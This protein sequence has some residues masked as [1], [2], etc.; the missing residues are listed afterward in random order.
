M[1]EA[2]HSACFRSPIAIAVCLQLRFYSLCRLQMALKPVC[3]IIFM[4]CSTRVTQALEPSP[5]SKKLAKPL[6]IGVIYNFLPVSNAS[7]TPFPYDDSSGRFRR[8]TT[9]SSFGQP[10][11]FSPKGRKTCPEGTSSSHLHVHTR[12]HL[13]NTTHATPPHPP[14]THFPP[15]A[16]PPSPPQCHQP[17]ATNTRSPPPS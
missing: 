15:P 2:T 10:P 1:I 11:A 14:A 4:K 8:H 12:V 17:S 13:T 3:P 5:P 9:L 16:S 6:S 7:V